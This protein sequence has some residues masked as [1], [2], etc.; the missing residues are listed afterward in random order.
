MAQIT[1]DDSLG[2][3]N[4]TVTPDVE[5]KE[6]LVDLIEG[7]AVRDNNLFHSFSEFNVPEGASIYFANPQS[8]ANILTRITG[9][10]I[11]KILGTLGVNGNAN[12]FLLNPNGIVFG[13]NAR[14]DVAGSF[15]ATTADRFVFENGF[16]YSASNPTA[17]P[18]LTI[19]IPVGLQ[20][21][22]R[23]EAIVNRS[24]AVNADDEPV[25]LQIQPQQNFILVG[26]DI[27]FEA[28]RVTTSF[29]GVEI[30]AV[31]PNSQINLIANLSNW[32]L[33][34]DLATDFRDLIL[35]QAA[36]IKSI[37]SA[38]VTIKGKRV[39]LQDGSDILIQNLGEDDG[40]NLKINATESIELIGGQNPARRLAIASVSNQGTGNGGNLEIYTGSLRL[41]NGA[42]IATRK[43]GQGKAGNVI[44]KAD[45]IDLS[46]KAFDSS[47]GNS[48]TSSVNNFGQG[49]NVTIEA[50]R[51]R[52]NNG[53][54]ISAVTLGEGNSGNLKLLVSDSIDIVGTRTFQNDATGILEI[55]SSGLF[56]SVEPEAQGNGGSL[57]V[58]SDRL[59]LSEGAK[60]STSTFAQGNAGDITV[61]TRD[62]EVKDI[63]IDDI[64]SL[65][66]LLA[67]VE[68]NAIGRGGNLKIMTE[69][70]R[71]L[72][73]GQVSASTFGNGNAGN[74]SI[75]AKSVELKGT[76]PDGRFASNLA[77]VSTTPFNAG[78]LNINTESLSVRDRAQ[79]NV[80]NDNPQGGAGNLS[81]RAKSIFLDNGGTLNAEV[82]TG[83]RGNIDLHAN[84]IQL[85]RGSAINSNAFGMAVGGNISIVSDNLLLLERSSISTNAMQN[86]GGRINISTQGRF[87]SPDSNISAIS[88]LGAF[89]SGIIEINNLEIDPQSAFADLPEETV[90][91]SQQIVTSCGVGRDYSLVVSGR[92]GIPENPMQTV[93]NSKIWTDLRVL[94]RD[95]VAQQN[96]SKEARITTSYSKPIEAQQWKQNERGNLELIA[97]N[98][99]QILQNTPDCSHLKERG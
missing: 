34:F 75:N 31:T 39:S 24:I 29:G 9:N 19:N 60:I 3:E 36:V 6:K 55:Y 33:N 13:E 69:Q 14:L 16:A 32:Q 74:V 48:I 49:G 73:G 81:V 1:P 8:V 47:L 7:G 94:D 2:E 99:S 90:E 72:D 89:F 41:L 10:N 28:G 42:T 71:I 46:G 50:K 82:N 35:S 30:A 45:E 87:I 83:D 97:T 88:E 51:L 96:T 22:D 78:S 12:L 43:L 65:S 92:G 59:R 54:Q 76:S 98:N 37:G 17:P 68:E 80:N 84:N 38:N 93:S 67:N 18:L 66:G 44:I 15:L 77:A 63:V 57:T 40:G 23:A 4:S 64:G 52:I 21:G 61:I 85:R 70:L 27:F 26:G 91:P 11:S 25:G 86:F 53:G 56:A 95:K 20:F 58:K 5:L 62:L 79:V